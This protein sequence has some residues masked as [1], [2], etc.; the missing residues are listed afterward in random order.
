M[1]R[2]GVAVVV[3]IGLLAPPAHGAHSLLMAQKERESHFATGQAAAVR[4]TGGPCTKAASRAMPGASKG[5][6]H[7]KVSP[8]RFSCRMK[9]V[10]YDSLEDELAARTDVVLGE[11][12]VKKNLAIVGVTFPE[13]G[14]LLWDVK[15]PAK[16]KFL[17]WYRT[18]E[19]DQ[20]YA[21]VNCGAF[22]DLSAK[23]DVAFLSIQTL[24]IVPGAPPKPDL[25]PVSAPSVEIID[26]RD[27]R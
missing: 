5:H 11:M 12:D 10:F 20:L 21:D 15:N 1:R 17:S 19:C 26:I 2:T 23:G 6:D 27:R 24:T 8:H 3:L 14:F 16:P 4:T 13:A 18:S 25:N 7:S 9:Q 22:V